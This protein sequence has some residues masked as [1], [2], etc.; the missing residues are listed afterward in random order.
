M[1]DLRKIQEITQEVLG[2]LLFDMIPEYK[3]IFDMDPY[4]YEAVIGDYLFMNDFASSLAR[5]IEE[6]NHSIF[7]ANS[8][9]YINIVSESNNLEVLNILKIGILEILYS[10][11]KSIREKT[12]ELLNAKTKI[13]FEEF[14]KLYI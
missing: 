10:S 14:S 4:K 2:P 8:I 12:Y 6:D 9:K 13:I 3:S 1:N 7:V 11:G 5:K